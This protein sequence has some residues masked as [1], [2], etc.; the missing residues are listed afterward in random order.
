MA[1]TKEGNYS[2]G[3]TEE[4]VIVRLGLNSEAID[5]IKKFGISLV[6]K[7]G[8][9][10]DKMDILFSLQQ[11]FDLH[12]IQSREDLA[13]EAI[14]YSGD[15]LA[16]KDLWT[17]RI[18]NALANEVE[19]LRDETNWKWWKNKKKFE[20]EEAFKEL[21]DIMHFAPSGIIRLG[22]SSDDVIK[23]YIEKNMENHARQQG[24]SKDMTRKEY[25]TKLVDVGEFVDY[26]FEDDGEFLGVR[27]FFKDGSS[28]HKVFPIYE[29]E[30][31]YEQG[32]E[33]FE[34]KVTK[35]CEGLTFETYQQVR[36][37]FILN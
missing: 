25:A 3:F 22:Y 35:E 37:D 19:E 17:Q 34:E 21:I 9:P 10:V 4:E 33:S 16:F 20:V 15:D 2:K 24:K 36:K 12:L 5:F 23:A 7:D 26:K 11:A 27:S 8:Y 31:I 32:K 14:N 6:D 13:D 28:V 1:G 18:A 30:G 29:L